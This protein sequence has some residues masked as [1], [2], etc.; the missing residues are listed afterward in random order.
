[1]FREFQKMLLKCS[2]NIPKFYSLLGLM[3]LLEKPE[4]E[5]SI[6]LMSGHTV[7]II[8]AIE[9]KDCSNYFLTATVSDCTCGKEK[10]PIS[11]YYE[12]FLYEEQLAD[13]V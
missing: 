13:N 12:N 8:E 5:E 6:S 4:R 10:W 2:K 7:V 3:C 11:A 9:I 1:M